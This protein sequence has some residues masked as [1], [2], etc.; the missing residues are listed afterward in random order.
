MTTQSPSSGAPAGTDPSREKNLLHLIESALDQPAEQQSAWLAQNCPAELLD[1]AQRL[2]NAAQDATEELTMTLYQ[3]PLALPPRTLAGTR[4]GAW[5]LTELLGEGGMGQVYLA[6]RIDGTFA[7]TVAIKVIRAAARSSQAIVQF[8]SERQILSDLT[9]PNIAQLLDGG[10]TPDGA[11]FVA[12]E[13]IDGLPLD[14]YVERQ[15]LTITERLQL[16]RKICA[17]VAH[18][19]RSLVIHRDIKPSNILVTADGEPK[20]LDFGIAKTLDASRADGTET[21]S[22]LLTPS[23]ASPEQVVGDVLTTATDIYSLGV[24][25]FQC[26]TGQR[27]FNTDRLSPARYEALITQERPD[28][29]STRLR[30]LHSTRAAA[31]AGDLDAI[32]LCALA[33]EPQRRY[34]SVDAFADDIERYLN[35]FP[36]T[37]QEDSFGY[38]LRKFVSRRRWWV[39]TGTTVA[40]LLTTA[41][42]VTMAQY[43]V[44]VA[45][46]ERADARFDQAREL[47]KTVM[48]EVYD[49]MS[50]VQG[51]LPA[52]QTLVDVGANYLD[53]LAAD[54]HAPADLMLDLG[55]QY[56][57]LSDL[58]G[59]IGISNLGDSVRSRE[60]LL[61]ARAALEALLLRQPENPEAVRQMI[62]VKRLLTNQ[63]LHYD[64]D[65]STALAEAESG[66]ALAASQSALP[67]DVDWQLQSLRWNLRGDLIKVLGWTNDQARALA[68]LDRYLL[69]LDD[70]VLR[71]NLRNHA[72]KRAYFQGLRGELHAD[73]GRTALAIPDYQRTLAH[74]RERDREQPDNSQILTQIMRFEMELGKMFSRQE[75]WDAALAHVR[76][77]EAVAV[78]LVAQDPLD[79][80]ARRNHASQLQALAQVLGSSGQSADG[81]RAIAQALSIYQELRAA[82]PENLSLVRDNA[83]AFKDAGDVWLNAQTGAA[84]CAYYRQA[85]AAWA[86]IEAA[87]EMTDFDR[88]QGLGG[89]TQT[90]AEH[91]EP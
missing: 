47:A 1:K 16:F 50:L 52:R 54:P 57:R 15:Q 55:V 27:P 68:A 84:A 67:G 71:D 32:V 37:A 72:G 30:A 28:A 78:R 49:A 38:R 4:I 2:L 89:L 75:Q 58:Y 41:L 83:N 63:M 80:G 65:T 6:E 64:M 73:A 42:L 9:H 3:G 44:A 69:E 23:Y 61:K 13:Y 88:E 60:L 35:G 45:E 39:A 43:R 26:L 86:A 19:H 18:A 22:M 5:Q 90:M 33:K 81:Q 74:Y 76:T 12:M 10:E 79:A 11:P 25:L 85:Q 51:T 87:G 70:Q 17:A 40:L 62:W 48:F 31:V 91:C 8:E 82:D 53:E 36:V 20:L 34:T 59:G 46:R 7:Q 29:P 56:A 14:V 21:V 66:L 77:G 24:V